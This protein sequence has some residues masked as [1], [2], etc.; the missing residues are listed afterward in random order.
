MELQSLHRAA[1]NLYWQ[2][3]SGDSTN[4][5]YPLPYDVPKLRTHGAST[6]VPWC[7]AATKQSY[8]RLGCL[9]RFGWLRPT[10]RQFFS[11][12]R[13]AH[14]C[15]AGEHL[16]PS[17]SSAD[18]GV[19]CRP[20][21]ANLPASDLRQQVLAAITIRRLRLALRSTPLPT[22]EFCCCIS[23]AL[24]PSHSSERRNKATSYR[25]ADLRHCC[26]IH[27]HAR[28]QALHPH[29]LCAAGGRLIDL[30]TSFHPTLFDCTARSVSPTTLSLLRDFLR[31]HLTAGRTA[32]STSCDTVY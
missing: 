7:A 26:A 32:D 14:P 24:Q 4:T 20:E 15:A 18:S 17:T 12:S 16:P 9:L 1:V 5:A 3:R 31:Q 28:R 22:V 11:H 10:G 13:F 29:E 2:R 21:A 8:R 23:T 30:F 27:P 6:Q 25:G 19:A